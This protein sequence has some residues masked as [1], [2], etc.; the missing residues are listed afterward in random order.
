MAKTQLGILQPLLS[1]L[2][3]ENRVLIPLYQGGPRLFTGANR[4]VC[5]LS[6]GIIKS[7]EQKKMLMQHT[8]PEYV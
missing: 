5:T 3:R 2:S 8:T 6:L 7:F 1:T 4:K